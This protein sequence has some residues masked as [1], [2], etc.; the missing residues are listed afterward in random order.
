[1][2]PDHNPI[3]IAVPTLLGCPGWRPLGPGPLAMGIPYGCWL[4]LLLRGGCSLCHP[5]GAGVSRSGPPR[6]GGGGVAVRRGCAWRTSPLGLLSPPWPHQP[7][8]LGTH[9]ATV[10]VTASLPVMH[11]R[12]V[13]EGPQ[14]QGVILGTQCS[15]CRGGRQGGGGGGST[16]G[17]D[18]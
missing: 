8:L 13:K 4:F 1:M 9:Q 16:E 11:Q 17:R 15:A 5:V 14:T 7:P 3:G 6:A 10:K 18:L 2:R 12:L